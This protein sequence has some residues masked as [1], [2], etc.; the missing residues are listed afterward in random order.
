VKRLE[1]ARLLAAA[2]RLIRHRDF[3][4]V[5]S[6]SILGATLDPPEEMIGSID[7]DLYPKSD[8]GRIDE[9]ARALGEGSAFHRRHGIYADP[10]SPFLPS[11]PDGWEERLIALPLA[12]GVTAWCLEPHDAAVSKYVRGE[13]RDRLWCRAGLAHRIL[14]ANTL[15]ERLRHTH[16]VEPGEIDR[17]RAAVAA[18]VRALRSTRTRETKKRT[19]RKQSR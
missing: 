11:L 10:V 12:T 6:L 19:K 16:A 18:D 8:P 4:I 17:A 5:G 13:E 9:I 3:V 1:L 15:R 7:V 14:K 2:K